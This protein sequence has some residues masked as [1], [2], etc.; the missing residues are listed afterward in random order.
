MTE[1]FKFEAEINQLMKLIINAF[2]SNKD[3]FLR[4]LISNASDALDKIKHKSLTEGREVL[5]EEQE[6]IIRIIPDPENKLLVIYDTGIGMTKDDLVKNLGTVANS[7]TKAFM[8]KLKDVKTDI[9][10]IGQFGVGFYS[11]FLVGE[12]VTVV[13]KHNDDV[14]YRWE[15]DAGDTFTITQDNDASFKRGTKII[16]HMKEDSLDYLSEQKISSI[17]KTHSEFITYPIMLHSKKTKEVE[18]AKDETDIKEENNNPTIEEMSDDIQ[19]NSKP[20][21]KTETYF[22]FDQINNCK[23]LWLKSTKEVTDEEYKQ[24]YKTISN[25]HDDFQYV[26]HFSFE[27]TNE[28]T[29]LLFIPKRAPFDMFQ[30]R[31][32]HDDVKLYVKKVFITDECGNTLVPEYMSFLKGMVDSNDLPLNVSREMLQNNNVLPTIKKQIIKKIIDM[33]INEAETNNENYLKFYEQFSKNIKL[34]VHDDSKNRTKLSKLLRFFTINHKNNFT[35]LDEY[36]NEMKE[37]QKDIYYITGESIKAVEDSPFIEGLKNKGYDVLMLIDPMDEYAIQQMKEFD[38]KKLVDVSREELNLDNIKKEE[39][40]QMNKDYE[41]LCKKIKEILGEHIEKV[42][43][44]TRLVNSPCALVSSKFGLSANMER[45]MKAQA[46]R[47]PEMMMHMKGKK[48]MEINPNNQLVKLL[49][50]KYDTNN[51]DRLVKDMILFLYETSLLN[52]G[53]S[54][55][56]PTDYS[57]RIYKMLT[58]ALGGDYNDNEVQDE[59]LPPLDFDINEM[60]TEVEPN[61]QSTMNSID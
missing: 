34:G 52:S 43:L 19:N 37:D 45:I 55:E 50:Q 49:K 28:F 41:V 47:N 54:I 44:S 10:L 24:F 22:E 46:L 58:I 9:N 42:I 15:S 2:Y 57:T 8:E 53:Y 7:G 59:N 29:V 21:K 12:K 32:K 16:I 27:G 30:E 4:E 5:G 14:C 17:I 13:T 20:E 60:N 26:S 61:T 31:K 23:P 33:L 6:F 1:S 51:E 35:S 38:N 39:K 48:I 18:I 25:D 56:K 3:V 11:A 40:E 36:I